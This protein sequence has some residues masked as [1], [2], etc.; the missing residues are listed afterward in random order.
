MAAPA[1]LEHLLL[2]SVFATRSRLA[3]LVEPSTAVL[4]PKLPATSQAQSFASLPRSP[5][6][7][8]QVSVSWK[9]WRAPGSARRR[10]ARTRF[11]PVGLVGLLAGIERLR[12]VPGV[13]I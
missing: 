11:W 3:M 7:P 5:K 10:W 1:V 2:S 4:R 6:V 8:C 13:A 12:S 9:K